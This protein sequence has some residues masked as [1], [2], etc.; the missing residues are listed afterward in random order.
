V[1]VLDR[2]LAPQAATHRTV[3]MQLVL[4]PAGTVCPESEDMPQ[5]QYNALVQFGMNVRRS[6]SAPQVKL[7]SSPA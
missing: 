5:A 6:L 1:G 7:S 3:S 2:N 4:M